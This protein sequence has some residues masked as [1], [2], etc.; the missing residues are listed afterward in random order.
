MVNFENLLHS[1]KQSIEAALLHEEGLTLKIGLLEK[2]GPELSPRQSS[3]LRDYYFQLKKTQAES[4]F[5]LWKNI[6]VEP[7]YNIL[8]RKLGSNYAGQITQSGSGSFRIDFFSVKSGLSRGFWVVLN[9]TSPADKR[10]TTDVSMSIRFTIVENGV[11]KSSLE[12]A[13]NTPIAKII[14]PLQAA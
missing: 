10:L 1:L 11:M 9:L 5:S 2:S 8:Q 13:I 6:V 3:K 4:N 14:A 12:P 7:V